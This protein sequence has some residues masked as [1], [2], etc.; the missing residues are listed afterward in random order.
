M[1][2]PNL[3]IA[4]TNHGRGVF[5]AAPISKGSVIEV[6]H[7]IIIPAEELP[8]I[9]RTHLHDYY[10]LWGKDMTACA[11]ALGYGSLYNHAVQPN[12]NFILDLANDTI[13]IEAI[14]DISP[15]E[16]ITINYNGEPGDKT[17]L[18]F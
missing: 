10:F 5:T 6:C 7:V 14:T 11:I 13:D 4:E 12:A 9:H 17:K 18:W 2:I 16:E 1:Q 15:G 8:I 3:Y